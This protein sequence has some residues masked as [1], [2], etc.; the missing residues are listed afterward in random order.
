MTYEQ[1][2]R[3]VLALIEELNEESELL[4]DDPDISAKIDGVMNQVSNELSR[5]KKIP[6]YIELPVNEGQTV[7]FSDIGNKGDCRVYQINTVCGARYTPKAGGTIL[8]FMEAGIAEIDFSIYP[9]EITDENKESYTFELSDDALAIMPYGVAADLLKSDV[10][11]EYGNV[12]A[13]RYEQ[14]LSRLDPRYQMVAISVEGGV[15][16]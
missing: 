4:T 8:K 3:R 1:M 7:T 12:Y 6:K 13:T 9:K 14:M 16:L 5:M 15:E 2:K 11:A 10:S